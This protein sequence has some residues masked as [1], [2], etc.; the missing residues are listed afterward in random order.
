MD[1]FQE[2]MY[3]RNKFYRKIAGVHVLKRYFLAQ[4][5]GNT[6]GLNAS[7]RIIYID[8]AMEN[9][10]IGDSLKVCDKINVKIAAV[11]AALVM[12]AVAGA[13][14]VSNDSE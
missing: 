1:V 14:S 3:A 9:S 10:E 7:W 13:V 5:R 8:D 2:F 4:Y 11:L 6:G 12:V